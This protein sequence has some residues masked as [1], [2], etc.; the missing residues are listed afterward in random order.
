[1]YE[2]EP[3]SLSMPKDFPLSKCYRMDPKLDDGKG[4]KATNAHLLAAL[5]DFDEPFIPVFIGSAYDGYSWAKLPTITEVSVSSGKKVNSSNLWSGSLCCV[6]EISL[7]AKTSDGQTI[8][9]QV[10]MAEKENNTSRWPEHDVLIT[11][12][13]KE[14][15]Q[16]DEI[17]FHLG[18]YYDDGDTY[19]TQYCSFSAGLEQFWTEVI[20]PDEHLRRKISD[21]VRHIREDW[22][23][24]TITPDGKV[25]VQ[26]V[27]GSESEILPPE[28]AD[29][30]A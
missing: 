29:T 11:K 25:S 12:A 5:G 8:S 27:D 2:P 19:D 9:S 21:T 22:S 4:I 16:N 1:M 18:G 10:C 14:E 13:A 15:L 17:W 6:T 7:T 30:N 28:S 24:I 23:A 3:V 20:G 26:L